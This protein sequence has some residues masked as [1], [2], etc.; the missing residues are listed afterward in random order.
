MYHNRYEIKHGMRAMRDRL[1]YLKLLMRDNRLKRTYLINT[2]TAAEAAQNEFLRGADYRYKIL[3]I[4]SQRC[5]KH[6]RQFKSSL[7]KH[8][9]DKHYEQ[10]VYNRTW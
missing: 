1:R 3:Q 9:K 7:A 4:H 6:I 5:T 2:N 10:T 8:R